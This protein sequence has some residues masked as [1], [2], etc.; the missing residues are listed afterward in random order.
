MRIKDIKI[1]LLVHSLQPGGMERVMSELANFFSS[2]PNTN[3]TIILYGIRPVVFFDLASNIQVITPSFKFNNHL[4]IFYTLRTML[5]LRKRIAGIDPSTILS[6]GEYFNNM[7]LLSLIG[8]KVPIYVSDRCSP[9]KSLGWLHDTLRKL[10]Y[11]KT[12]GVI[13]QT[14]TAKEI[15]KK[16][17]PGANI[18]V[19][20]NPIRQIEQSRSIDRENIILTV[21]RLIRTKHHDKLIKTFSELRNK[22]WKLVIVGED[23][24]RQFN[25][26]RLKE[27][28]ESLNCQDDVIF[29]GL[30]S[31]VDDYYYKSKI[32]VLTSSSEG[33]PNV[34]GEAM[35]AGLPVV[36]FDCIAG[37]SDMITDGQDGYLI[38]LN[39]YDDLKKRLKSL[40]V[41]SEERRK[42]GEVARSS[43]KRFDL[44]VVGDYYYSLITSLV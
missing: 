15:Y 8:L 31:D 5:F 28:S 42:I 44:E 7:V 11:P 38:E 34:I 26:R 21:G 16:M 18:T 12:S 43:I 36:A 17:L 13:V 24:D 1:C 39:N 32:F 2:K 25:M 29:A 20:G 14:T 35:S 23:A 10:L 19:I 30:R 37:P 9:H 3:V 22:E 41:N 33:F 27:L 40:M 6:F 4:R